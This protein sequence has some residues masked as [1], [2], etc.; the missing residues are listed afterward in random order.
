M[1]GEAATAAAVED[2]IEVRELRK[3]LGGKQV[4]DGVNLTVPRGS[5]TTILGLSGCGKSTL[6]KHI[7]GLLKPDSGQVLVEGLD[8]GRATRSE[9]EAIRL[10]CGMVF[11]NSAL[12]Q[13]LS[14]F[15]NVALPL[16][17][18]RVMPRDQIEERVM[19]VLK[20]VHLDGF[21]R[22][23]PADL[24]G[25]M[26]KRAGVAR[27]IVNQPD[28]LLYDEPRTG[29]DPVITNT[30]NELIIDMREKLDVTSVVISHDLP[31][32]RKTSDQMAILHNGKILQSGTPDEIMG[33]DMPEVRQFV[34][35]G[36]SGP[37]TDEL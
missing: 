12:L 27:A 28:I 3:R 1:T 14:V 7:I 10:K 26:R 24:S 6:V 31:S 37:L 16:V 23:L 29:L 5:T 8:V 13:S 4:L 2:V 22:Y 18:H 9:L 33:S 35:G 30:V 19:H 36:T 21:E 20:L 25:G 34:E 17:E 11:Q 32:A 15:D